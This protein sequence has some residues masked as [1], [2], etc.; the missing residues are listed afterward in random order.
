MLIRVNKV[1]HLIIFFQDGLQTF[2]A[3]RGVVLR[4]QLIVLL[5]LKVSA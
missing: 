2:G 3:F 5:K 4:S 1:D